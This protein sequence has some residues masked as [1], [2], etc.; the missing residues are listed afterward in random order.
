[1]AQVAYGTITITDTNDI[2]S[3]T[4]EYARNQDSQNAPTSGW[5]TTRPDWAQGYYIW[6][7]T[8]IH[9]SGTQASTDTF[10]APVCLTGSTGSTGATGSAGRS[11][12]NIVTE[13]TTATTNATIAES[14]MGSY[15]WS[16]NV[17]TYSS[18]TPAYWVRVTNTYSNP[19][20]TEYIIYKDNGITDAMSTAAAA[21]TTANTAASN[22]STALST[23]NTANTNAS[24]ALS[25]ANGTTQHF[26]TIATDYSTDIPAGSYIT[27]TAIDTFK[28]QKTGGNLLTR[29]NGIWIRNGAITLASLTGSSLI[30]YN[31]ST[32]S[33]GTK[34]MELDATTLK[35]Y[36]A[37]GTTAQATFGGTQATISGT[38]NVYDGKI[39]NNNSN[40][41]YI[42][43]YTDYNQNTSAIIKSVGTAS[44]QLNETNT[45]RV[46]TN[47]IHTA[48]A[49]ETGTDAFKLHFPK[50]NDSSATSKYWDY[51]LHLPTSYSDKFLYIRNASGSETLDNLLND[52]DDGGYD[53]WNYK[54]YIDGEGNIHAGDIYSHD[55][56]ISGSSAPYLLKSGGTITGNLEVNGTLTKGSN[57]VTYL[58]ATPT[59]GQI[60]VAD[61]TAGGIKTSGYTIATSVPSGAVFTDK[62]VQTSQANTTKLYLVG[63]S[64]TGTNTGTLNYD[65]GIYADTTAGALHATTYNGYTLAA[66]SAKGVDTSLTSSSTSTNL[67]TSA[68][69]ATLVRG[70]LPLTGGNVTGQVTF[71][72]SVSADE[73]TVGDLVVTGAA[74]FANNL[75]ANTINGVAVGSSPKFTDTVTTVSVTGSGNAVTSASASNGVVTLTKGTTF[76]TSHNTYT[77]STTGTGNAVTAVSLSGTTF[78]VTKG[79]TYNNYS[80]PLAA[81]GTRGGVQI[82]YT[83][84]ATNRNYAVQLSSEKMYVN[85]PWENT[86][87]S[88]GT[89]LSLSGTTFNHSNSVTAGTAGTSSATSGATL[90]VPYITYD[91][92]GH[93]TATGTHTH[94]I[95]NISADTLIQGYLNIHPENSPILIPFIHNDIAHLLKRGG[96]AVVTYDGTTQ[97]TDLTNCFDGSGSYWAINP[98]GITTIIIELTLHKTFTYSNWIY[99]DFGNASWRASGVTIEVMNTNYTS[100]VWT[101][102]YSTTTN[103]LGHVAA[104]VS[105][106]PVGASNAG[107]GFNKLRFTFTGATAGSTTIFRIAQLGIYNYGSAGLRETYM[108]RGADDPIFRSITP[109][110]NNTYNLGSS[111]N[112]WN[113]VYATTFNGTATGNVTSVQYDSTNKKI[114]YTKNSSNT[115]VVTIATIKTDLGSMPASDVYSWAKA[116]SKPSYSYSEISSAPDAIVNATVN[117]SGVIVFTKNSGDTI[118][119]ST[120][121]AVV[122]SQGANKLVEAGTT[123]G[124][125]VG[126]AAEPVYFSAGVP[127]KG[128]TIPKLNNTTTGGTFYAPTSAGTVKQILVST[129]GTPGW[130]TVATGSTNGTIKIGSDEYAV[131]GLA[132]AAYKALAD[133]SSASAIS[134]GTNVTTERDIYYGLP[135]INNSHAYTSSTTIYA[136]TAGGTSTQVLIGAG[137]TS[138]PVWTDISG[139]VPTNAGTADA[140]SSAAT[141]AL[142]G[143]TTGSASSTKGWSIT[144]KTDRIST[145]GD[146]RSVATTPNDYANKI[147]FQGLKTNSSFGSPSTD[148]YSYVIGLRGWSDSSGGDSHELAFNNSGINHR[149]GATTSWGDWEKLVTSANYT[150][151]TV[152]KTGSGASG[153]WGISITG[154]AATATKL[155]ST[156]VGSARQ[157]IYLNA[158]TATAGNYT[159]AHLGNAGK[160]NMNDVGRLHSSTGMTNLTDPSNTTD[161]PMSGT[162]KSTSWHLYWDTNYTDDPNGSNSWVAQIVN[163]AGTAQWWVRSRS[164]GTITN[165]TA[166]AADWKHLVVSPQAGQGSE[167]VPIYID[168]NG[169]TQSITSYSGNAATASA[170]P[171]SGITGKPINFITNTAALST[172]GWKTLGG[173][174]YQSSI[175]ISYASSSPA[176][177][178]SQSYSASIVFG[179]YDTKGLYDVGYSSPI[180]TFGGGFVNGS[181]DDAPNWYFKLSGTSGQTY[182]L[183][184]SSK[185][186]VATDGTGASGTWGISISGTAAQAT[187]DAS[188]NTIASTYVKKAGDTMTGALNTANNT[189]NKIGDDVQIG[190]INEAGTLGIQGVN[191]NTAI[192][193]TTYNQTTKTTGGKI[194]WDGTNF[195]ITGTVNTS[196]SGNAATVTTT[197]D[198]TNTLYPIGVTSAAT[199]TLKRN[200]SISMI[201]GNL[202]LSN[203]VTM[204]YNS[205]L[206]ALV[207]SFAS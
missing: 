187:A 120:E 200:T 164:G 40:Y 121:I 198:T 188:G 1:M 60:L 195:T 9:K 75:Q 157:A 191:G 108:S 90:A 45:W 143:D 147:I 206:D 86:T 16:N 59:S 85:V 63:T 117:S 26:W 95:N 149:S 17:P 168:A 156:T 4:I 78:T 167:T 165:G 107:G 185:T 46:S 110:S 150:D 137:T 41:W 153:S 105:H 135:T 72:D 73:L 77:V 20:S 98:T 28:S 91:A 92:Q 204:N 52:L 152:T 138:A 53:Y 183:P 173:R 19:S 3:I 87:Y 61:G 11:L 88:A 7:R 201:G 123:T 84:D 162:T 2:E 127:V 151:Y 148:S 203:K 29:S 57:N 109:Y 82:G 39:G 144:T 97:S 43:N 112:K 116:S 49:P 146:N 102:K 6:Q 124:I 101:S 171:W 122:E 154:N 36:D 21:N 141:V 68:A 194:S 163:K 27:N 179:C 58:T 132:A 5:S 186:L 33:Q 202:T 129:A 13:Y 69:V 34:G 197:A 99:A 177:W 131:K 126:S 42:G 14:N 94:T 37:T 31:P 142:T 54:F 8:R 205:T 48:W 133:S 140:F 24:N 166:W 38:I 10:G 79:A 113:T 56:L 111:S 176:T 192:R 114:T 172:N 35:F 136:P 51:G 181:T 62:N 196:I 175:A 193:F 128:N 159:V 119:L 50:F 100:D 182:T 155:G 180:V 139:L 23:A 25:I 89:G 81:N 170:V 199:T 83:T 158:G 190:D 76:L 106:T 169:H 47:R 115:D 71:G 66:A 103:A 30:F 130:Q 70:Y 161:N 44:I 125:S 134:T 118:S 65:S 15:T 22:A 189:W 207:F 55:V 67:P 96:S 178:N 74:S 18:S 64:T 104:S 32:S 184:T 12:T 80:L 160:S 93:I 174:T 145:V